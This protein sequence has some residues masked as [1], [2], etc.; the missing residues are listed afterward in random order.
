M[1]DLHSGVSA[2]DPLRA[3]RMMS[4]GVVYAYAVATGPSRLEVL[5]LNH[6]IDYKNKSYS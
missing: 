1:P 2:A 3:L 6:M 4:T 5:L